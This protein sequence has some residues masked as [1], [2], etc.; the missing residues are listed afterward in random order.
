MTNHRQMILVASLF[1]AVSGCVSHRIVLNDP[2]STLNRWDKLDATLPG[3]AL[4]IQLETGMIISGRFQA[5]TGDQLTVTATPDPVGS[6]AG[7]PS[8][9]A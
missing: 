5:S 6:S 4:N 7:G 9:T 3:T 8:F 2:I 1:L